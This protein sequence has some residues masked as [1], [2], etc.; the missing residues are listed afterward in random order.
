MHGRHLIPAILAA[1]FLWA[2]SAI[3]TTLEPVTLDE[4][5]EQSEVIF[6]GRVE[7]KDAEIEQL[8][9]G[10][11]IVTHVTFI[12][13]EI[14]KGRVPSRVTLDFLGGKMGD[15]EMVVDGMPVFEVG[16][17]YVLFVSEDGNRACPVVGWTQGSLPLDAKT[18]RVKLS[19]PVARG[20]ESAP[21]V[22][23]ARAARGA[24]AA[25]GAEI[26][27]S[28]FGSALRKKMKGASGE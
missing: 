3:A 23:A 25:D 26:E 4:Q 18:G 1:C 9:N 12:P 8:E 24:R 7:S 6:R 14:Y 20:L 17:E 28:E 22:Q 16:N 5:I 2:A 27:V 11:R 15:V 13:T 21:G 19:D 10:R